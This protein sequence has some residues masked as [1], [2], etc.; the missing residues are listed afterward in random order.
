MDDPVAPATLTC[1][2]CQQQVVPIEDTR[3]PHYDRE[4][5]TYSCSAAA[6]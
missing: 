3:T 6:E 2:H 1:P 5:E 4:T